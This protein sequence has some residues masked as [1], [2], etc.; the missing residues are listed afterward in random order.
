MDDDNNFTIIQTFWHRTFIF[1]YMYNFIFTRKI[2]IMK[3]IYIVKMFKLTKY[4]SI[5]HSLF[6]KSTSFDNVVKK[7]DSGL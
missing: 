1:S 5:I 7:S 2:D 3:K 6:E 4:N